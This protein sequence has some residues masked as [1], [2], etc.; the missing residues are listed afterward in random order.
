VKPTRRGKE[1]AWRRVCSKKFDPDRGW[2]P[3]RAVVPGVFT[4]PAPDTTILVQT[5]Y[6]RVERMNRDRPMSGVA[7]PKGGLGRGYYRPSRSDL[8]GARP[9]PRALSEARA[10]NRASQEAWPKGLGHW[11]N[12]SIGR[13]RRL[14]AASASRDHVQEPL[15][16]P[17]LRRSRPACVRGGPVRD[18]NCFACKRCRRTSRRLV[19]GRTPC[20]RPRR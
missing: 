19:W 12:P 13:K 20:R 15:R 11:D 8:G 4:T 2:Y 18:G 10:K 6:G 5:D 1:I 16:L 14:V 17:P 3:A 7:P 9:V